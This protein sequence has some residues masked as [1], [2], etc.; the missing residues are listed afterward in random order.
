[1]LSPYMQSDWGTVFG[2]FMLSSLQ[3]TLLSSLMTHQH[4][5]DKGMWVWL[6][7]WAYCVVSLA[8]PRSHTAA[9]VLPSRD[10]QVRPV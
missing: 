5:T 8:F 2:V 4:C 9:S 1:M 10:A 7:C 3:I 6:L